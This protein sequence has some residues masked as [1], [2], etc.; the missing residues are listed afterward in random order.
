MPV[1]FN[2]MKDSRPVA[3]RVVMLAESKIS[4]GRIDVGEP[5]DASWWDPYPTMKAVFNRIDIQENTNHQFMHTIG[6]HIYL[7]VFG[8]RIGN[9]GL[10]GLAFTEICEKPG[11]KQGGLSQVIEYYHKN[12]LSKRPSPMKVTVDPNIAAFTVYLLSLQC[13]TIDVEHRLHQFNM[14][15]ALLPA[16]DAEAQHSTPQVADFTGANP[17]D[18]IA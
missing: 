3:G 16:D 9:L 14:G 8:D 4:P 18:N 6:G 1:I 12:R 2:D 13:A 17:V 7:Y 10:S 15:F 11:D 5:G